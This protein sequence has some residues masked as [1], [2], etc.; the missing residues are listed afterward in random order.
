MKNKYDI[1]IVGAGISG[2]VCAIVLEK[3]GYHGKVCIIEKG[4]IY[5][6]RI[7]CYDVGGKCAKCLNCNTISGFGGSVHYGD[8]VKLS[9]SPCGKRLVE[10]LGEKLVE[11]EG[12]A[13]D[14]MSISNDIFRLP[15]KEDTDLDIKS[16]PIAHLSSDEAKSLIERLYERIANSKSIDLRLNNEVVEIKEDNGIYDVVVKAN[17]GESVFTAMG[18]VFALGRAGFMLQYDVIRQFNILHKSVDLSLGYRFLCPNNL[19]VN[20][21]KVHADYKI[22]RVYNGYKYKTFCFSAG[23]YGGRIKLARYDNFVLLD[24]HAITESFCKAQYSN[25]AILTKLDRVRDKK[26]YEWIDRSVFNNDKG[27]YRLI[28]QRYRDFKGR[29]KSEFTSKSIAGINVD[30][31]WHKDLSQMLTDGQHEGFCVV[32]ELLLKEFV[33]LSDDMNSLGDVYS[34]IYMVGPEIEGL[35]KTVDINS[36]MKVDGQNMYFIGDNAGV[37]QGVLQSAISAVAAS[38]SI[39]NASHPNKK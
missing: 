28:L 25:F 16:Y 33:R 17:E 18:I 31:F 20:A 11:Y 21:A 10:L 23:E 35:W 24:G 2:I 34:D 15:N 9:G 6:E 22:S 30:E 32:F 19:L 7:C 26:S 12:I 27:E 29:T 36:E 4:R 1:I 39:I 8:S 3:Y 14:V 13:L 38:L 5:K 37:S